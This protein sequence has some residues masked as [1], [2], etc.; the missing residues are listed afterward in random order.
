ML[1]KRCHFLHLSA[2]KLLPELTAITVSLWYWTAFTYRLKQTSTRGKC[3]AQL[4]LQYAVLRRV[5]LP[6]LVIYKH[7][8]KETVQ[9]MVNEVSWTFSPTING[10]KLIFIVCNQPATA[11]HENWKLIGIVDFGERVN[12]RYSQV[13]NWS[14]KVNLSVYRNKRYNWLCPRDLHSKRATSIII[15]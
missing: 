8:H 7:F 6:V 2:S 4:S 12:N 10:K 13:R 11:D 1:R 15:M 9:W 14:Q 3:R 5:R